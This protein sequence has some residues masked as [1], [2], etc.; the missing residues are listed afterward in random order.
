VWP[1]I[2]AE[3]VVKVDRGQRL[4]GSKWL[5]SGTQLRREG[6][7]S[8]KMHRR[9]QHQEVAAG[10]PQKRPA[11]DGRGPRLHGNT[12]G[13]SSLES[14]QVAAAAKPHALLMQSF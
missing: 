3:V 5:A 9:A 12:H 14:G 10:R 13:L 4:Q 1:L 7:H 8:M 6:G 2:V 11:T